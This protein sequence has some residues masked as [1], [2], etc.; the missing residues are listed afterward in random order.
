MSM[1]SPPAWTRNTNLFIALGHRPIT[2]YTYTNTNKGIY[3]LV[4]GYTYN[5]Y[6]PGHEKTCFCPMRTTKAQISLR[7][8]AVC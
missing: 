8:G 1:A 6:E 3:V 4:H 7:I 2:I 5:I